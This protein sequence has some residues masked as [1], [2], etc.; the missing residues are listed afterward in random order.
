MFNFIQRHCTKLLMV[1][2]MLFIASMMLMAYVENLN[3]WIMS[4][5][6]CLLSLMCSVTLGYHLDKFQYADHADE[7]D[8]SKVLE[9]NV[10]HIW[11]NGGR[12]HKSIGP[13]GTVAKP[14]DLGMV[15][16][17]SAH[18][19]EMQSYLDGIAGQ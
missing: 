3:L 8:T 4:A 11:P 1:T 16:S 5:V 9:G 19:P 6:I 18:T 15:G 12:P 7:V 10:V 2:V 13:D 14:I 17:K